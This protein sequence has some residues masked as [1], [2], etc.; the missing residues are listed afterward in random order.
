MQTKNKLYISK[1][2][3]FRISD[4]FDNQSCQHRIINYL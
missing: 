3:Q 1:E 4:Y 2:K